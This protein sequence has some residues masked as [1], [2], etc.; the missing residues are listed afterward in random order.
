VQDSAGVAGRLGHANP[1][2]TMTVYGHFLPEKDRA[3]A[4]FLDDLLVLRTPRL[5]GL[6]ADYDRVLRQR[7]SLGLPGALIPTDPGRYVARC[8]D[9]PC[10]L[11]I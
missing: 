10:R 8:Q 4:D 1:T 11:S 3:A 5:A 6:K 9:G 7:N 2:V